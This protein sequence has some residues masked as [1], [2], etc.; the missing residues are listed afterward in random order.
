MEAEN[1]QKISKKGILFKFDGEF[2]N[3]WNIP[4]FWYTVMKF[5]ESLSMF[6]RFGYILKLSAN[7]W[8]LLFPIQFE[9]GTKKVMIVI[10]EAIILGDII[11]S[12]VF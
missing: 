2:Y 6:F 8:N 3:P 5:N 9:E 1:K 7:M 10:L 12:D 11:Y 4:Q